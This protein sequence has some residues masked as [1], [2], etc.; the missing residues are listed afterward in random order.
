MSY[1]LEKTFPRLWSLEQGVAMVVTDLHGNWDLY[2][3]YRDRFIDLRAAGQADVLIFT[4]DLIHRENPDAPD[5][6]VEIVLDVMALQAEYGDAVI[7]L[8]GNHELPHIYGITLSKGQRMYTPAF[9]AALNQTGR[10]NE[11]IKFFASLPFYVRTQ[12]GVTIT[13]AGASTPFATPPNAAKLFD[14]SHEELLTWADSIL[15][16]EDLESLQKGYAH[17]QGGGSY[18][19]MARHFLAVSGPDDTRYN[20]LLRGFFAS[21]QP[22]FDALVWPA[23][24]TR[25]EVEY[26][27]TDYGIFLAAMLKEISSGF[28]PQHVV[29]AGH[30][31][32]RSGSQIINRNH[33]RLASGPH[34]T[35]HAAAK[36]LLFNTAQPIEYLEDLLP[37]LGSVLD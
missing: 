25:C 9:E 12:A 31:P 2:Q 34:A 26:G 13:H 6:S 1:K 30:I 18:E 21:S 3:R 8:C 29:V 23:L 37:G 35:P 27:F 33:L 14:W 20:D 19:T 28:F 32:T 4:G 7:Y 16:P 10:H 17:F 22:E 24:F 15:R 36:Y 5:Q 11:V